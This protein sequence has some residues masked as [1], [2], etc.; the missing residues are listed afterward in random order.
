MKITIE[1]GENKVV[2]ED[3]LENLQFR[4]LS[5]LYKFNSEFKL[6]NSDPSSFIRSA[7]RKLKQY[8]HYNDNDCY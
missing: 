3:N 5:D 2:I 1:D 4:E 7:V 6:K 8:L